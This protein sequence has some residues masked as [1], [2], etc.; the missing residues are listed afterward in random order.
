[1]NLTSIQHLSSVFFHYRPKAFYFFYIVVIFIACPSFAHAHGFA[2]FAQGA[3]ATAMGGAFTAIAD[4][5]TASYYNPA[6]IAYLPDTQALFGTTVFTSWDAKF[7]SDGNSGMPGVNKGDTFSLDGETSVLPSLHLTHSFPGG[8]SVG[9]SGYSM[10]GQKNEWPDDWEGRFAPGGLEAE[11]GSFRA[12]GVVAYAPNDVV[13]VAG[14]IFQ[15][16][17]E[18]SMRQNVWAQMLATEFDYSVEGS[19][20]GTGWIAGVLFRPA[21]NISFGASYRSRVRHEFDGLDISI[22]PDIP[23][24]GIDDTQGSLDF[25]TPAVLNLGVAFTWKKLTISFDAYWTE[26]SEQ[27]ELHIEFDRP[28]F[29]NTDSRLEK[30]WNDTWTYGIGV[31]YAYSD[32]LQ[33]RAGYIYDESPVPSDTLDP[34][35]FSGD[36]QLFCL[37][38]GLKQGNFHCD[39]SYSRLISDGRTF[40]NAAGDFPN[41]GGQ[42]VVG[43]FRD[44]SCDMFVLNLSYRF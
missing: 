32:M 14:G 17:L 7:E 19:A 35:V 13:S 9:L 22:S 10:W 4:D 34:M 28:I 5:P 40:D 43:E 33:F 27:D 8:I 30:N 1:M 41:P 12:Q 16:W 2:N 38:L 26:W 15:E 20:S 3:K 36:S 25:T 23:L 21:E 29:G 31:E 39:A 6:G 44:S 24:F 18:L 11:I 42:R 37:G